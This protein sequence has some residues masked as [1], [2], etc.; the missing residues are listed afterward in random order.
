MTYLRYAAW[1]V[2][3]LAGV[4][5][6]VV[7]VGWLLPVKHRAVRRATIPAQPAEVYALLTDVARFPGWRSKVARIDLLPDE[8]ARQPYR[9]VGGDG[10][11]TYVVDE[12]VADRRLVTRIADR[13]LPFGGRWVYE[14]TPVAGGTEL[15][16]TEEGEVYNPLFR[17]VSR[18]VIG[19]T[20]TV[21]RFLRDVGRRFGHDVEVTG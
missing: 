2:G 5:A 20:A 19:H 13:T 10:A 17:A 9:E 4:A 3:A 8:N 14:L 12:A 7:G 6:L 1:T 16:I 11:I 21:D 18:F 15:R